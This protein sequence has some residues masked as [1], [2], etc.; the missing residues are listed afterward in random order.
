LW[1]PQG[2]T[3]FYRSR[4]RT[5]IRARIENSPLRVAQWDTLF[6]D[7]FM[8]TTTKRNWSA[9]PDGRTFLMIGG[10]RS[11]GGVK[12]LVD[13][14]QL[15]ALTRGGSAPKFARPCSTATT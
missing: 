13:W 11:V 15:P 10:S 2:G 4:E 8:R 6:A 3:L 7:R 1:S 9:F 12:A 5:V 14:T